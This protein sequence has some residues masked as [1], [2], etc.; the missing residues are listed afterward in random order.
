MSDLPQEIIA[1]Y[2]LERS[3][4]PYHWLSTHIDLIPV[5][6]LTDKDIKTYFDINNG[7]V[8]KVGCYDDNFN[9]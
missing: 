4:M 5:Y 8:A 3:L 6:F 1:F 7:L 2:K 9:K